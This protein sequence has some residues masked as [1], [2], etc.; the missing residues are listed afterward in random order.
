MPQSK[1]RRGWKACDPFCKDKVRKAL[2]NRPNGPHMGK[3]I[4]GK[5]YLS[6]IDGKCFS[7]TGRI[8]PGYR[9]VPIDLERE[10]EIEKRQIKQI[11]NMIRGP[12]AKQQ[13]RKIA[14][15]KQQKLEYEKRKAKRI[16]MEQ[17]QNTD[18]SNETTC[19]NTNTN[20]VKSEAVVDTIKTVKKRRF[21]P[22]DAG[23]KGE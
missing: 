3:I 20:I 11:Q 5:T 23:A 13:A 17:A 21:E 9:N 18:K 2:Y 16:A 4:M 15:K 19:P 7:R 6:G 12:T 10:F 14:K 22:F 8:K 1:R